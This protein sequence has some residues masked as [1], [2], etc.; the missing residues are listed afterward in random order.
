[1]NPSYTSLAIK[2]QLF[3]NYF[4]IIISFTSNTMF[5]RADLHSQMKNA[6]EFPLKINT[7]HHHPDFFSIWGVKKQNKNKNTELH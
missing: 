4:M 3:D 6:F 7:F 5:Q 1:M 2:A